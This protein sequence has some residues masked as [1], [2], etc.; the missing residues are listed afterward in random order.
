[1]KAEFTGRSPAANTPPFVHGHVLITSEGRM[2]FWG[3]YGK[4]DNCIRPEDKT[5]SWLGFLN[6]DWRAREA[7]CAS[8]TY[9]GVASIAPKAFVDKVNRLMAEQCDRRPAP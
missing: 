1:M 3:P 9:A 8:R 7:W 2:R 6:S 5:Q 4:L